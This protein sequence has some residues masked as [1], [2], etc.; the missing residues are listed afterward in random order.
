MELISAK[1]TEQAIKQLDSI[2]KELLIVQSEKIEHVAENFRIVKTLEKSLSDFSE[3]FKKELKE[4]VNTDYYFT[5]GKKLSVSKIQDTVEINDN[6]IIDLLKIKEIKECANIR[7]KDALN[8]LSK[9]EVDKYTKVG[10]KSPSIK[11]SNQTKKELKE[12]NL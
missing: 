4:H 1:P 6:N 2:L 12:N 9:N 5:D 10:Q 3:K 11:L 7:Y 8:F